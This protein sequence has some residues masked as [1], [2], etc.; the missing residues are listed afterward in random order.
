ML[1]VPSEI[2]NGKKDKNYCPER[3]GKTKQQIVTAVPGSLWTGHH[4]ETGGS[5]KKGRKSRVNAEKVCPV[6]KEIHP[7]TQGRD[8][9]QR[10]PSAQTIL[11]Y[12][13]ARYGTLC[14]QEKPSCADLALSPTSLKFSPSHSPASEEVGSVMKT[15]GLWR[16][17]TAGSFHLR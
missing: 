8:E 6:S 2:V 1:I 12:H 9:R 16:W 3:G 11:L 4:R 13:M 10:C 5:I 15:W 14:W 17:W 7:Y